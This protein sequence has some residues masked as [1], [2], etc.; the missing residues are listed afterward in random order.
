MNYHHNNMN[1]RRQF[2]TKVAKR[3]I[4]KQESIDLYDEGGSNTPQDRIHSY[5]GGM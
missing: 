5:D 3:F 2:L 4:G 1:K